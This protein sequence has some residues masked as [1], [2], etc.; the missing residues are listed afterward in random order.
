MRQEE[1]KV[2]AIKAMKTLNYKVVAIG[3]SYNDVKMLMEADIGVLYNP[4]DN[5]IEEFPQ[6]PVATDYKSLKNILSKYI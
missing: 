6:F 1:G 5:I 4:P 2:Q 3:D